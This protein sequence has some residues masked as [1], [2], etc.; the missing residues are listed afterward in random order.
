MLRVHTLVLHFLNIQCSAEGSHLWCFTYYYIPYNS[1][2]IITT[3]TYKVL[4]K[5]VKLYPETLP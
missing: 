1:D 3:L 2:C 4:L 5:I